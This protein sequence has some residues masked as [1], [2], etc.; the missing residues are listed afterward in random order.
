MCV[1]FFFVAVLRIF[2]V[3]MITVT[4]NEVNCLSRTAV[5][6]VIYKCF[7]NRIENPNPR[8][9]NVLKLNS[10]LW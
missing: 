1:I 9:G 7:N 2:K 6:E 4:V 5:E 3:G 10:R 8:Y